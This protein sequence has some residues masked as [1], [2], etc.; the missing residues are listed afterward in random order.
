MVNGEWVIGIDLGGSKVELGLVDP[1]GRIAARRRIATLP[2]QGPASLVMRVGAAVDELRPSVPPGAQLAGVGICS[3]GPVDHVTGS[4][5]DPPNLHGLHHMPLAKLL[6]ER[7]DLPVVV[8]H[9]AKAAALGDF[10][11]GAGRG[12][13]DMVFVVVGTGVGAAFI[14]DGQLYRGRHNAAGE[15]GHTTL[16]R[17]G[18]LCSCGN[19]GCV[20]TYL[21]GPWLARRYAAGV[22]AATV[23]GEQLATL[24]A[25]GDP[26]AR[27]V[28]ADAGAA[29]GVA[30]ATMA[31]MIDV[32]LYVIGGSVAKAGDLLLAPARAAAPRH[33]FASVGARIRIETTALHDDGPILGC[34]WLAQG[35]T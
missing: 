32:D 23:S 25:A 14:I 16:D 22:D 27:Q 17:N 26:L 2:Q 6:S 8:E 9:D 30:V 15:I 29:L 11:F 20:E 7:L 24:A 3:P 33:S 28:F 31:M 21:S 19:R 35:V 4:L 10:H 18:E 1:Q 5:I 13:R 34:A 12:G